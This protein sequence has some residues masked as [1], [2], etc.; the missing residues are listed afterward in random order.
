MT[1]KTALLWTLRLGL[2]GL[3]VYTGAIKLADPHAF[4][5]EIHNYQLFPVLAPVLAA[6]LPAVE[7]AV[8][9]ALLAGPRRWLRAGALAAAAMMVVFTVAV[10]SAVAR[11]INITCG[12]F[13]AGSDPVTTI[14]VVR[15]VVL[16]AASAVLL[17]LADHGGGGTASRARAAARH[18]PGGPPAAPGMAA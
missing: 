5:L 14:T 6:A 7:I 1:V 11:G 15:D 9:A 2:G 16:L 18:T 4:A 17:L 13:G 10:S 12:C 3:F 8:G